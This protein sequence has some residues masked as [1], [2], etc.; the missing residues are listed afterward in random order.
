MVGLSIGIMCGVPGTAFAE[1]QVRVTTALNKVRATDALPSGAS[2]MSLAAARNE[3]EAGQLLI[4]GAGVALSG[5]DVE[6]S[7]LTGPGHTLAASTVSLA[8]VEYYPVVTP[9]NQ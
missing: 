7:N 8:R 4:S 2:T 3:F 1:L 6:A 9:S 5:V